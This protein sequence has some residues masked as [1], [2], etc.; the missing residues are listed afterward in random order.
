MRSRALSVRQE[1]A[2]SVATL[3]AQ[4]LPFPHPTCAPGLTPDPS[5]SLSPLPPAPQ[6]LLSSHFNAANVP[7]EERMKLVGSYLAQAGFVVTLLLRTHADLARFMPF[8]LEVSRFIGHVHLEFVLADDVRPLAQEVKEL[9]NRPDI[10]VGE[11]RAR[12]S[13]EGSFNG[14]LL[15]QGCAYRTEHVYQRSECM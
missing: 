10:C 3:P 12:T 15:V 7:R 2:R 11:V 8:V 1:A 13:G 4:L 5:P 6:S 14:L 9:C